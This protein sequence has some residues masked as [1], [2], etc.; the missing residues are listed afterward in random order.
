[1]TRKIAIYSRKS[2]FTGKGESIENQIELCRQYIHSHYE[3]V[4][5]DDILIFED[6]GFSGGNTK[7]PQF[8]KM[9]KLGREHQLQAVVCYRLD[10]ISRNIGD[11]A[12]L[13]DEFGELGISFI[14]IKEQFDTSTSMGKAMMYIASVFSQLER[15]TTSER[16]RDNM[17]ELAKS[18]RWLGGT[19]PTGYKSTALV[20]SVTVDGKTRKAYKLDIINEEAQIIKLI[21]NKFLETKSLTKTETYLLQNHINTKNGK[22]YTR[23]SIKTILQNPVYM[24]ADNNS[25]Q[26][27]KELGVSVYADESSFNGKF[28]I[29]SYNKTIQKSG[30]ANQIR[31]LDEW[32]VSV[33]KHKPLINSTDWIKAQELLF[34]NKSKS[35]R[36]PKS[37]VALL[38][39]LLFCGNCNS[40]MRPK[41]S[42]R[43]NSSGE[44]IYSYLCETKE[45]S[46]MHNCQIKNPNGNELDKL[47]C[48]EIKKLSENSSSFIEGLEDAKKSIVS[49]T[50]STNKQIEQLQ[51]NLN[52]NENEIN[53][54]VE[55]LGKCENSP[56]TLYITNQINDLHEKNVNL[57]DR[58]SEL[59]KLTEEHTLSD[60]EFDIIKNLLCSFADTFEVM[61]VEE[62][63]TA[64]R[65]FVNK[66]VWD[67]EN[68]S[69]YLFG[70]N[71][72]LTNRLDD[73]HEPQRAD[74]E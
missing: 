65:V 31:N 57:N 73:F 72:K 55:A 37:N 71:D 13:I 14:S 61:S 36:Q 5:D 34:Q 69:I 43:T 49:N 42:K 25:L 63:R 64:L 33:G 26:Y 21:F 67:G 30:K 11:F 6:E 52:D 44:Q 74:C 58:I 48:E 46:R 32:I 20:G 62:K 2:K 35:Y 10:R 40:Y 24:S 66:V 15:E 3:E 70:S 22:Q 18:G 28:G 45:K 59:K 60:I 7:R 12:K 50:D 38:S 39:G 8:Q 1:M 56:A 51:K 27:F 23:F 47:L 9:L 41:L 68:A 17:H 19:T 53:A 16:I 29:M 4:I 54:L